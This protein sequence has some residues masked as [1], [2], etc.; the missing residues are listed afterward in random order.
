M[1]TV[2]E[3]PKVVHSHKPNYGRYVDGCPACIAKYPEGRP[4]HKQKARPEVTEAASQAG[5]S[6]DQLVEAMRV[7]GM[8]LRKPDPE[9]ARLAA[10]QKA[11][12]L[13]AKSNERQIIAE[14]DSRVKANQA[15]CASRGHRMDGGR[16]PASAISGQIHGDGMYHGLCVACQWTFVRKPSIDEM[17]MGVLA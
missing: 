4:E 12:L 10:E 2:I 1:S 14:H 5:I 3:E 15:A 16:S 7:L 6:P 9:V 17:G 11:R 13:I 8:E